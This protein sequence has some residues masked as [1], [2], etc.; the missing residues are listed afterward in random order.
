V[1]KLELMISRIFGLV[2]ISFVISSH[3]RGG[4][5]MWLVFV[6]C[7][8]LFFVNNLLKASSQQ[9]PSGGSVQLLIRQRSSW[10]RSAF[11]LR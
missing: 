10:R 11:Q 3:F 4:S 8:L 9:S 1:F 6:D 7:L 5:I 2:L